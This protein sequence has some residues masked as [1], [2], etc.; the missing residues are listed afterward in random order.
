MFSSAD[1]R[2]MTATLIGDNGSIDFSPGIDN[3]VATFSYN[4]AAGNNLSDSNIYNA[5]IAL[6]NLPAGEKRLIINLPAGMAW[7]DDG[8]TDENLLTQLDEDACDGGIKSTPLDLAPI[9]GYAYPNSGS[10]IYCLSDGASAVAANIKVK[11]DSTIETNYIEDALMADLQVN[12]KSVETA[13]VDVNVPDSASTGGRFY[14]TSKTIYVK[15][16]STHQSYEGYYRL[17]RGSYV[18]GNYGTRRLIKE[19]KYTLTVDDPSAEIV[20]SGA[21]SMWAIDSSGSDDG[22]YVITYSPTSATDAS[23]AVPYAIKI[24]A[25]ADSGKRYVVSGVGETSY[26]LTDGTTR[27]VPFANTQKITFEVLPN[28][29]MVTIGWSDLNPQNSNSANNINYESSVYVAEYSQGVLGVGYVNNKGSQDSARKR[30]RMTFDTDVLG[31][32][33][34]DMGCEPSSTVTTVHVKTKNG[35]DK[36]VALNRNCNSYGRLSSVTYADLGLDRFDYISEIEYDFGVIP[37]ATQIAPDSNGNEGFAYVGRLLS[38]DI[39]GVTTVEVFDIDNPQNTTGVAKITTTKKYFG[40]LDVTN[41]TTQVIDAGN[42]LKYSF[43]VTNWAGGTRYNNT[44]LNP[45]IYIRQEVKDANGNFLPISN[46]KI[47]NSD[48][49]GN[50]DIT[51]LFGQINCVDTSSAKVCT[52][53]GHNVPDG[54]ASFNAVYIGEDG[55]W[56]SDIGLTVSWTVDTDLTTPDQSYNINDIIF[57]YDP[58]AVNSASTHS[59]RGDP[60]GLSGNATN[61]VSPATNNYYQVRGWSSIGVENSGKHAKSDTWLTWSE[62]ASPITIG[63]V[64]GS[65]ADMKTT[66]INNSGVKVAG[67]TTT[68]L[69]IPKKGDNWGSLNNDGDEFEFSTALTG[70]ISNPNSSY[71]TIAYGKNVAPSDNGTQLDGESSKFTTNTSGWTI[72]DWEE[73]NCVK[74]T[75]VNIPANAPGTSDSYEFIYKL[76]VTDASNAHDGVINTWR[77]IYFQQ[78][79][80]SAGDIFA[81]WYKGSYVSVQLADGKVSG[82]IFIDANENGKKDANEADLKEAGWKVEIYDIASNRL[83]QSTETDANG[84]YSIIEL[85][86]SEN[87]YYITVTNK[88]PIDGTGTT[89][90]FTPKGDSSNVGAYNTDNQAE[91]SKTTTPA[92]TTAYIG[93]ISPSQANGAATYNIGVVEYVATEK[94]NGTISF[95]DQNNKFS[96]RPTSVTITA[97]ASDNST[98][99]IDVQTNG[100]GA[101]TADLPKYNASGERL[102]YTFSA[103]DSTNYNKSF[104][105]SNNGYTYDVSYVQKT[106]TLTVNHF[107]KGSSATLA[108]TTTETVY[109]G[110]S[111]QTAQATVDSNYEFD[112]V[113]GAPNG[114]VAGDI[115]VTYYYKL[116]RG[117]VITHFYIKDSSTSIATDV[118]RKYDY[119]ETYTTSPLAEIPAAYANYEL[120]S[121][122]PEGYTGIVKAPV[123]EVTYFYQKKDPALSSSVSVSAPETVANK[124]APVDYEINYTAEIADY[125]G[126]VEVTLVDKLPYPIDEDESE[127]DD[128]DYNEDDLTLA[129]VTTTTCNTYTGC[130]KVELTHNISLVYVG[131]AARDLL[132][133][134]AEAT[135]KLDSKDNDAA[136]SAETEVRTPSKIIFRYTDIDGNE[137]EEEIEEDGIVGD[138]SDR[139]PPEIPGYVLVQD[140]DDDLTFEE[141]EKIITY[142]YEKIPEPKAPKTGDNILAAVILGVLASLGAGITLAQKRR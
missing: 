99:T 102:S 113:T 108:G 70:A 95:S 45:I 72:R 66:L 12:G 21:N 77:P 4:R 136:D 8:S 128:G 103:P 22:V 78:L 130:D 14:Q 96:T 73:V 110:Q 76:K 65:Y 89:Y 29:E 116:K 56:Y 141:N 17:T 91:G 107:K 127:L 74:I 7:V 19:V 69:P 133:N 5:K 1:S 27:T 135:V 43:N 85:S 13:S 101:W 117:T 37:A 126:S 15:S 79:T 137:I 31:V 97:T 11:V 48:A 94:Y 104:K 46:L 123:T 109:W 36:T 10:R 68:Y 125:I 88:H 20:L 112:F 131:A 83:V 86:A 6:V 138:V 100:N 81:G 120:V 49:R 35:V 140:T 40:T 98:Q 16:G 82:Q 3:A 105:S 59:R 115:T 118:T 42:Q 33:G 51:S 24:P 90:L 114:T 119:T 63:S 30:I 84:K 28:S 50:E 57:L 93:P 64:E 9:L 44:V 80:N 106:A 87:N 67:P 134:T 54:K 122:K 124:V 58:D 32:M 121:D 61:T 25:D 38:E 75:A 139:R 41:G 55:K 53:D 71:F 142:H 60:Y 132:V 23:V 26:Y 111:Y 39:P 92:H 34:F 2:Y 47:T 129:W 52:I 18:A 62:G